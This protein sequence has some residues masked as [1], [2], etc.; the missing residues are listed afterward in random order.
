[1]QSF[2][3]INYQFAF[4]GDNLKL[5]N[6]IKF[7]SITNQNSIQMRKVQLFM[8][9]AL[10]SASVFFSACSKDDNGDPQPPVLSF[11]GGADYVSTDKTLPTGSEFKV[12]ITATPNATS[13]E[14]L[15]KFLITRTFNNVPTTVLDSTMNLTSLNLDI[16]FESRTEVGTERLYFEITDDAGEK[17]S[18]ELNITTE[19]SAGE[20]NTYQAVLLGGQNNTGTGSFF[21]SLDGSVLKQEAATANQS[22]VDF[23]YFFG[24]TNQ[25]TIAAPDDDQA[26]EAWNNLFNSWTTKNATK[27]RKTTGVNWDN[28][29]NDAIIVQEAV[30]LTNSKVNMLAVNDI[31]SFETAATSANPG[32]KGLYKVIEITGTSGVDRAIKIE[33]KIQK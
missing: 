1:M 16:Y 3:N 2:K 14:K 25:A 20:I 23:L 17:S 26:L 31:I 8:A 5:K 9:L 19:L 7:K 22:K 33:V 15:V 28:V 29:T 6:L 32:K 18:I 10:I 24:T 27:F 4:K 30:N 12:G 21:V 13:N 11:K